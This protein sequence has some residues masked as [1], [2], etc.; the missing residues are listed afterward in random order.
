MSKSTGNALD[1]LVL[2]DEY[3]A[4]SVRLAL[5]QAAAPGHDVPLDVDWIDA[6]RRFGNKLWNATRFAVEFMGVDDVPIDGGYPVDPG[7]E[8]RWILARLGEVISEVDRLLDEY[9][10]SDAY[11]L[12]Y[13]FAWSE[14]FDWYLEMAKIIAK[15]DD[16]AATMRMTLGVVL[17]DVLKAFH[18]AIPFVTEEL[19]SH[20]GDGAGLL[21]TAPWPQ[22]PDAEAPDHIDSLRGLVTD[23]RRFRTQHQ[24]PRSVEIPVTV[25]SGDPIPRWWMDQLAMLG[26]CVPVVGERP[27][28]LAGTT[29]MSAD[30]VEGFVELAG[31][32]DVDAERP[33]IAKAIAA[34]EASIAASRTK[35]DNPN[36]RDRAP[37]EVV[38]IEVDR[39]AA[40]EAELAEQQRLLAELG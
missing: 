9:R 29:R 23:L 32:I 7:P 40:S 22:I 26:D 25:V 37:A 5:I 10:L 15:D 28:T 31:L 16:R 24:I 12:L 17:R 3:G 35:L 18:P 21:V 34:L 1:P 6:S 27:D 4:D 33:R 2:I 39:L 8:D 19:W 13:T 11:D 36:F 14:V 30:G 20:L 38:A